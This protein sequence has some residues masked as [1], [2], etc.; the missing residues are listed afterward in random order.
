M[1]TR[2][3]LGTVGA[4]MVS[5]AFATTAFAGDT[6]RFHAETAYPEAVT[7]SQT[8]GAFFTGSAKHGTIGKVTPDGSY[9]PFVTDEALV[10][11]T[12]VL[13][14]DQTGTLWV[15]IADPGVADRTSAETQGKLAELAGYDLQ[16]GARKALIDLGALRPGAHFAND[17]ALGPDGTLY[18]TDSFAPLVYMV[19]DGTA[20]VFAETPLFH[21][22]DG[23]NLNGIVV[24]GDALLVGKYNSGQLFRI[25]LAD[26]QAVTEVRMEPLKGVDGL[27]LTAPGHL[28]AVQNLGADRTV[29]LTSADD[30]KTAEVTRSLPSIDSMPTGA[31]LADGA[32]WVLNAQL[33]TLFD[34][35]AA[36]VSD[37]LLQKF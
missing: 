19:K 29:E 8:Q 6:I 2:M 12:G 7:W 32:I 21:D 14:D 1:I 16:T 26:P 20:S 22:G 17:I 35:K 9:A 34:P 24:E 18:V 25:P 37:W 10:T 5:A 4:L 3:M 27:R 30:W 33:D 23:F 36:P 13:A 11:T 15:A 31:T 28:V